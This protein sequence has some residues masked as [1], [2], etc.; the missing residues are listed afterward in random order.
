MPLFTNVVE[1]EFYELRLLRILRTSPFG[2]SRKLNFRFTEFSE[3]LGDVEHF[4]PWRTYTHLTQEYAAFVTWPAD[5][6]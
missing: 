3:V 4:V 6:A 5:A 2:D 1:V